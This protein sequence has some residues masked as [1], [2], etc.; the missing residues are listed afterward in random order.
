MLSSPLHRFVGLIRCPR[1][2]PSTTWSALRRREG[3]RASPPCPPPFTSARRG[4]RPC[5]RHPGSGRR[6]SAILITARH[7]LTSQRDPAATDPGQH[8]DPPS[9]EDSRDRVAAG[10]TTAEECVTGAL[11][12]LT[13]TD[14]WLCAFIEV[15]A[16]QALAAARRVDA[17]MAAGHPPPRLAGV[18]IAVKG[19]SGMRSLQT[20]LLCAA[21]AIPIGVT[22][23][24]R[25]P[26]A[27]TWGHT[28][29]GPSRN[30]W[31]GGLSPGGSSAGS[32][33]AVAAGV[34]PLATGTDGAGSTRVPAAWCGIFGYKPTAGLLPVTDGTAGLTVPAPL[35]RDPRDL[36]AWAEVVLGALPDTGDARTVT[37]SAD[38]G[39]AA[40]ELDDEVVLIARG[41]AERLVAAAGL[42]WRNAPVRLADPAQAWRTLREPQATAAERAAATRLRT[43]ND[44][45]LSALFAATDLLLTPTTP[46]RPHGHDGPGN[47]LSV[48]L[49]WGFNLSG[50][51]AL[52]VPAG[53]ITAGVPV[54]LQVIA[55][56]RADRQLLAL[57]RRLPA[58][59]AA[60]GWDPRLKVARR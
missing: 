13:M 41:A 32:A 46:G 8:L 5:P 50:H 25:G 12:R 15:A 51:P 52:S 23:T 60:P 19:R 40:D 56:H 7:A 10:V 31:H 36:A 24:P 38:L 1:S 53:F 6:R 9:A 55:R 2:P 39:Y 28:D 20:R 16:E 21:G 34:V 29:R 22:S 35:A 44:H 49:T 45:R 59:Q 14:D 17:L 4:G 18:P 37:W 30:P 26:G 27:Q 11:V 58:A 48:A 42:R 43:D 3:T 47:H 33:A 54:G 57:A